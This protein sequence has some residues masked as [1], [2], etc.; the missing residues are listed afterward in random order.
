[1]SKG[2]GVHGLRIVGREHFAYCNSDD[3]TWDFASGVNLATPNDHDNP[4]RHDGF[5][6]QRKLEEEA[7]HF[8]LSINDRNRYTLFQI[9][10][11][12][13]REII[14]IDEVGDSF[15]KLPTIYVSFRDG[16]IPNASLAQYIL[17][18]T[19]TY[20]KTVYVDCGT[21]V[22]VFPDA[23]RD[24][25]WEQAW[26][27]RNGVTLTTERLEIELTPAPWL[28]QLREAEARRAQDPSTEAPPS[29]L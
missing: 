15:C 26:A 17:E 24:L 22:R 21:H 9:T 27:S 2:L 7:R 4:W 16:K 11:L 28:A 6:A 8:W 14:E 1:M 19:R 5:E 23:F 18:P 25:E 12:P 10:E 13:Y 29:T 20:A 3:G